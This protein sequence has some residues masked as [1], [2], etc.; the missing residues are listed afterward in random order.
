MKKVRWVESR[1]QDKLILVTLSK[2]FQKY[3]IISPASN[4]KINLPKTHKDIKIRRG[5]LLLS[6][7]FKDKFKN[8]QI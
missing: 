2:T 1:N 8:K 5:I 7:R 6:S 3:L 4:L